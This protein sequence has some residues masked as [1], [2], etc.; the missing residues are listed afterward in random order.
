M[1]GSIM[2]EYICESCGGSLLGDGY[3]Q[4]LHCEYAEVSNDTECDA[5]VVLCNLKEENYNG[6]N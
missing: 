6:S 4:P 2:I 1:K 3:T 5:D